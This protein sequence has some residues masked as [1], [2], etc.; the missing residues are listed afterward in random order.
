MGGAEIRGNT[1]IKKIS[2]TTIT[3]ILNS[4]KKLQRSR[5]YVI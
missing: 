5:E 1:P 3:V 2:R 4:E